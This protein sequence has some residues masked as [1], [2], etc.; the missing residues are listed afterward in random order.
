MN[1]QRSIAAYRAIDLGIFA[2]M[3]FIFE[4][5]IVKVSSS[6]RFGGQPY[7]ASL[8]AAITGIVY[9][10]WG[11]WG[12]IH[13]ALSGLIY[14]LG[15][16]ATGSQYCV[17]IIGN[18]FSVAAVP[19]INRIG[20]ER[21]RKSAFMFLPVC[22]LTLVLMQTGRALTALAF[23][24][25]IREFILFYTTDCM[26]AV[27]TAVITFIVKGLNGIYEDQIHY[28]RRISEEETQQKGE[29]R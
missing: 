22:L 13:A 9:M 26:S 6:A 2:I 3:L 21:I 29:I 14:C 15:L 28:L 25:S 8:A 16:K 4:G 10:R 5:I 18:L 12:A 7:T 11:A 1:K 19:V 27:F 17:Y 20:R 23:G 24:S